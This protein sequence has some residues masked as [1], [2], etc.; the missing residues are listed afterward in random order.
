MRVEF[1]PGV[2]RRFILRHEA[3]MK[4]RLGITHPLRTAV[5]CLL[6]P[7]HLAGCTAWH[8]QPATPQSVISAAPN[9]VRLTLTTGDTVTIANPRID[10]DS[11]RSRTTEAGRSTAVPLAQVQRIEVRGFSIGRTV[12]LTVG[13]VVLL[14]A[15]AGGYLLHGISSDPS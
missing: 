3:H 15:I 5:A 10:A 2:S 7:L 4:T 1:Q 12:G 13:V 9:K 11:V 6:L 14:A 8:V